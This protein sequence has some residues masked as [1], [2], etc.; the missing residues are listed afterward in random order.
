[1]DSK[2]IS[3]QE[4]AIKL[5]VSPRAV[6]WHLKRGKPIKG[7]KSYG[8]INDKKTSAYLIIPETKEDA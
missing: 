3:V 8:K 7:V 2:Y 4:L 6:H 5:G 1:M